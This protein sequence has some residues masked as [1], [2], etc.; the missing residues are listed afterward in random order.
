MKRDINAVMES[1]A[2]ELMAIPGV[3]GVAIG[4]LEDKTPC[5]LVLVLEDSGEITA[6]IPRTLEGHPVRILVSGEI[7]PM[8]GD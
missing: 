3:T 6:K 1:H 5:V 7:K 2:A 4:E 8:D